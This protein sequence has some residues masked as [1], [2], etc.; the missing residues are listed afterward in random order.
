MKT[1]KGQ[2]LLIIV[3]MLA[4]ILTVVL[5]VTFK[6]T[7]ETKTTKLEEDS[8]KALAAAEA[9]LESALQTNQNVVI[10]QGQLSSFTGITG[11]ATIEDLVS[12][13]FTS[14]AIT[15]DAAYTFYLADYNP[16]TKVFTGNSIAEPVTVCFDKA[17][18]NPAIEI[19]LVK[20][21]SVRK[22]V[23]D[24]DR[25]I[26]T[27]LVPAGSCTANTDYEYSYVVPATEIG[28]DSKLLFVR[29]LYNASKLIFSRSS[30]FPIQGR[31]AFSNVVT[32]TGVSKKVTLFQSYPQIPAEFYVTSF[33]PIVTPAP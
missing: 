11:D 16:T 26:T 22:Y 12:N 19:T 9:A 33:G 4:T 14:S 13:T 5:A 31:T 10:G 30:N 21:G 17:T 1:K 18:P 20:D 6:S 28:T 24:P 2:I 8:Q 3:M 29:T 32:N 15:K 27:T 25:R 7:N 23:I